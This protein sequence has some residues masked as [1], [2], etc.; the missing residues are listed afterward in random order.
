[1]E[2]AKLP[3]KREINLLKNPLINKPE[4]YKTLGLSRGTFYDK[5]KGDYGAR[6]TEPQK[7]EI[8]KQLKKLSKQLIN[9][10]Y[11]IKK[12]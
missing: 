8:I 5:L 3:F 1:M 4:L 6:F 9:G 7:K 12:V 10:L 11:P 2:K